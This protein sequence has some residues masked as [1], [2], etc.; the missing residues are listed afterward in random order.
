[1]TRATVVLRLFA[2]LT[3]NWP[4][5]RGRD[6][7]SGIARSLAGS[8]PSHLVTVT[9]DG[10]V[11]HVGLDEDANHRVYFSGQYEPQETAAVRALVGREDVVIDIGANFGWYTTLLSELVGPQGSV[12]AFEPVPAAFD[13]LRDNVARLHRPKNVHLYREAVSS[14]I[15]KT[16]IFTFSGLPSG[17]SSLTSQG[18]EDVAAFECATTTL[19]AFCRGLHVDLIKCD[20]EGA[21]CLVIEGAQRVLSQRYRPVWLLELTPH[22]AEAFG[23]SETY[24][25]RSLTTAGY[26]FLKFVRNRVEW[27]D[28]PENLPS[29]ST[30]LL[31]VV[32]LLHRERLERLRSAGLLA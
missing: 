10:R 16:T 1:V 9:D 24:V 28:N 23:H 5:P 13:R 11:L 12:H 25:A 27:L 19:D 31:A 29:A 6:R 2:L 17:H 26:K 7:L 3:R 21:E 18:R 14:T 30:N 20:V 22:L 8:W 4:L 15:G 32:P